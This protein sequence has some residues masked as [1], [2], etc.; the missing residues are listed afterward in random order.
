MHSMLLAIDIGNSD[1]TLGLS[2][3]GSWKHVWRIPSVSDR[4]E[5]FYGIK[6]RDYFFET[7]LKQQHVEKIVLSSVV[8]D[9]T[10]KFINVV[11]TLFEKNPVVLGPEIYKKL[12]IQVLNPYEIGSDLVA[13]AVAAYA[14]FNRSCVVVDFGT[15]LTF[16]TLSGEGKILGV[17]IA[18]G[19]K[20]A[21]KSLSQNA[22]KLFDVPLEMPTSA[23]GRGTVHAI[24]AGTLFGY[25]ALVLG[26]IK[27]IRSELKDDLLPV[28]AT[29][30]LSAII[31]T[32]AESMQI[33]PN[34][35]L[36]GLKIIGE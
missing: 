2:H 32:L 26:M 9:L 24:Q 28:V 33:E 6:I 35:T 21:I 3:N 31:T 14:R 18:P 10:D 36:D 23:L 7:G 34:L 29:G 8:P 22:A 30:G 1:I 11:V 20:T 16:T 13:N 17:A 15:A 5:L 25:E 4:P 12:T 27:R 19:L